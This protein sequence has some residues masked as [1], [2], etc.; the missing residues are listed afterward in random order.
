MIRHSNEFSFI[1][2]LP[3]VLFKRP[4]FSALQPK[5]GQ[6]MLFIISFHL[7]EVFKTV[8]YVTFS[9]QVGENEDVLEFRTQHEWESRK[10]ARPFRAILLSTVPA[11]GPEL[12]WRIH[13]WWCACAAAED[14]AKTWGKIPQAVQPLQKCLR[15]CRYMPIT[16]SKAFGKGLSCWVITVTEQRDAA[17]CLGEDD[18][19]W[20]PGSLRWCSKRPFMSEVSSTTPSKVHE[21]KMYKWQ[22]HQI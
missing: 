10:P 22:D 19:A 18:R 2:I 6:L 4:S 1:S 20:L 9:F 16:W 14:L 21:V 13:S 5:F 15:T 8:A 7:P 17:Q 3:S 11:G 12:V